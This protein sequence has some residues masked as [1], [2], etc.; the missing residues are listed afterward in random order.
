MA[1]ETVL[2]AAVLLQA[3]DDAKQRVRPRDSAHARRKAREVA[4]A[5][6]WLT[7]G[8]RDFEA[9][10]TLAGMNA[11]AVREWARR[12]IATDRLP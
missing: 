4:E 11:E 1:G 6:A 8:G 5:R 3:I 7:G 10:C 9:V 12:E 2:W